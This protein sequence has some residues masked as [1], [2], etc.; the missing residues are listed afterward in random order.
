MTRINTN[1]SSLIAQKTLARTNA[2]LQTSLTRLSTGLRINT[3]KDDPAGLIASENLRRDITSIEKAITNSER[4]NQLIAT[5]DS[6]LGQVSSLLNDIRGLVVE[7]ANAGALSDEQI[8]AN[9]L[10]VDS[11]LEAIDRIAQVTTFQGRKILDGSLDFITSAGS[12]FDKISGLDIQQANLGASGQVSVTI[13]VATAATQAQIDLTAIPA[14]TGA[15]NAFS[16]VTVANLVAQATGTVSLTNGDFTLSA[17][18]GGAAAGAAGNDVII[19]IVDANT[20]NDAVYV[21]GTDTLTVTVDITGGDTIQDVVDAINNNEGANFT[22]ATADGAQAVAAGDEDTFNGELSGGR[23]VGSTTIRVTADTAGAAANGITVT[24]IEDNTIAANSVEA[25]FDVND[26]IEVR[27]NGTVTKSAI[28]AEID[29]LAGYSAEV[30]ASSG[31]ANYI[32]TIDTVPGV[33]TLGSGQNSGGGLAQD[34]VFSI[35]GLTGAEVFSFQAG[36]SITQLEAAID[37][38]SDATGVVAT[39]NATTLELRSSEYGSSAF[40]DIKVISENAGG[41]IKAA[42]GEGDRDNGSD[43]DATI[44]GIQA[45]GK[46]N[47]LSLNTATLDLALTADAGFTGSVAFTITGG[48]ARFQLGPEVVSNQQARLGI[49]SVN[50]ATLGGAAGA[51]FELRAGES[52][53]LANNATGAATVVDEVINKITSLR[54]RLGAFQKTTLETNIFAL[55]DTLANLTEAQSSIRDA[56]FAEESAKLTRAQILVQSGT[57]VL[58]IANSNPQNVLALLR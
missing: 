55:N 46:G 4:A 33:A 49:T 18:A 45:T 19:E 22:A 50:T 52:K 8:V 44:N 43:I 24:F 42:V 31:D 9:Q 21:A 26:D 39:V 53:S 48:G 15:V 38:V 13:N 16:D 25:D 51:L 17:D 11:S 29:T 1:V 37:S 27:I 56:D 34:V 23:D 47:A 57:S 41:T 7:A 6:A 14:A 3:G 54:G 30:I 58:A 35:A 32:D 10:Q 5:A 20:G 40:V 36:T 2:D 28:A 12:N